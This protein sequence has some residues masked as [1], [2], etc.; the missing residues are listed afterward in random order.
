[1]TDP[2][3]MELQIINEADISPSSVRTYGYSYNRLL[4][5]TNETPVSNVSEKRMVKI[6]KENQGI[7]PA[8]SL[9]VML[10]IVLMIRRK[11][12]QS[13]ELLLKFKENK[14]SLQMDEE[15][16]EKNNDLQRTLPSYQVYMD[17]IAQLYKA[18][19]WRSYIVNYL[20]ITTGCRNK[21]LN[22]I[23]T[24]DKHSTSKHRESKVNYLYLT[25]KYVKFFRSDYKTSEKY[26]RLETTITAVKFLRAV[27]EFMGEDYELPLLG[28]EDASVG[29]TVQNLTY[30]K[31][32]QAGVYKVLFEYNKSRGDVNKLKELASSRGHTLDTQAGYYDI[33]K[34]N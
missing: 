31:I 24:R 19:E 14:L 27:E 30:N 5:L 10:S 9:N 13:V 21:D 1:M 16:S 12:E 2:I 17:Y 20:L 15:Q 6:F 29:A 34:T 23:V 28:V 25:K 4:R 7:I 26:G 32:G 11:R 22:C 3:D 18:K 33:S 8:N